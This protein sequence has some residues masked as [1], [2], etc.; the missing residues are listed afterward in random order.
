MSSWQR[1]SYN[2]DDLCTGRTC[3]HFAAEH[4]EGLE[5]V[6]LLDNLAVDFELK[7]KNGD[8]VLHFAAAA[9]C[10]MAAYALAKACPKL[11]LSE[12][13]AGKTPP[14]LA[15]DKTFLEVLSV[16]IS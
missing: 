14:E 3:L 7:D 12:N 11:C 5:E 4:C 9:G 16:A 2:S 8:S 13:K 6:L 15:R 1:A 10:P